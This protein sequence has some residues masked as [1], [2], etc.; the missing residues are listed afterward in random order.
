MTLY[1]SGYS[2][3]ISYSGGGGWYSAF[4]SGEGTGGPCSIAVRLG[5]A[6]HCGC[7]IGKD[8]SFVRLSVAHML[9]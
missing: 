4:V 5:A 1:R 7:R 8:V 6:S 2:T 3:V 9:L